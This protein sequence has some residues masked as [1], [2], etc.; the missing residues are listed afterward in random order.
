[1]EKLYHVSNVPNITILEPRVSTHGKAY[2]YATKNLELA[3][4][5]GSKK[6]YGDFDGIYGTL[7]DG[8]PYFYEAYK[9]AFERRFKGERCFIY[10]V[11]PNTFKDGK[12]SFSAEVVSEEPVKVLHCKEVKDLYEYLKDLVKKNKIVLHPYS[13]DKDYQSKIDKHIEDRIIRFNC[14]DS[15]HP[16]NKFC[17]EK[18][19]NVVKSLEKRY[20]GI[21]EKRA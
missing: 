6:S 5:F 1:M 2:V 3:L 12:T 11:D 14:L 9:G 21:K 16:M 4:L 19:P 7:S 10:E 17:K 13:L 18:F 15:K 8:R 20:K